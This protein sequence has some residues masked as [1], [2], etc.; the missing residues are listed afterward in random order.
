MADFT[1]PRV[2]EKKF[3]TIPDIALTA[4]GTIDGLVTI[5]STFQYKVGMIISLFSATQAPRRLKIK[6]VISE[7]QMHIGEE[8]T[9]INEFSDLTLF[10]V[11]DTAT[12]CYT[13]SQRP[14]IDV[15]EIQ[16]QVYEE[17]PTVA[18]RT[19]DVDWLGRP[20]SE[21]N[22]LPIKIVTQATEDLSL[23]F[24]QVVAGSTI[25]YLG[26][27]KFGALDSE[28]K[29]KIKK[30]ETSGLII[31]ITYASESFDQIWDNRMGLI[32]V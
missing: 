21:E 28:P 1:T 4:N 9:K 30:I 17:E 25:M 16:R 5:P 3:Y 2:S 20:Y 8:K 10:L 14:V 22:P 31:K 18:L 15:L 13:E 11:S 29:W 23:R 6:R 27:G 26:E 32:Y 7:T 24:D 19:H 12:V